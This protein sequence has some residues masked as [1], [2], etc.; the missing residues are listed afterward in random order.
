MPAVRFSSSSEFDPELFYRYDLASSA[1]THNATDMAFARG[2][3]FA[4]YLTYQEVFHRSNHTVQ[5]DDDFSDLSAPDYFHVQRRVARHRFLRYRERMN[6]HQHGLFGRCLENWEGSCGNVG[7]DI[8]MS[9]SNTFS[10]SIGMALYENNV[11]MEDRVSVSIVL[12]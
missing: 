2:Q 4:P 1:I 7:A 6:D 3:R 10:S 9:V 5:E 8:A 12:V 11:V